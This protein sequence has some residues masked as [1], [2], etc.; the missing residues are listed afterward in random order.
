MIKIHWIFFVLFLATACSNPK[1]T[2][3]CKIPKPEAIFTKSMSGVEQ[4]SFKAEGHVADE[5]VVFDNGLRLELHQAGCEK[6]Y[7]EYIFYVPSALMKEKVHTRQAIE[8]ITF[9]SNIDI[10]LQPFEQW[11]FA[12]RQNEEKFFENSEVEVAPGIFVKIDSI[13]SQD[14]QIL[15]IVFKGS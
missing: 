7:Q 14:T 4:H 5:S 9:L 2:T 12:I 8:Q 15:T 13:K 1:Q 10:K 6:I 3:D 11:V